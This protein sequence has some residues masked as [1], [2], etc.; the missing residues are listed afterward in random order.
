MVRVQPSRRSWQDC[1][2]CDGMVGMVCPVAIPR[3]FLVRLIKKP[4]SGPGKQGCDCRAPREPVSP[5]CSPQGVFAGFCRRA[6]RRAGGQRGRL[7]ADLARRIEDDQ[8]A[9]SAGCAGG[10]LVSP[11]GP[12]RYTRRAK[13]SLKPNRD[14]PLRWSWPVGLPNGTSPPKEEPASHILRMEAE[15]IP[16]FQIED[17][18][19]PENELKFR[20]DLEYSEVNVE[21]DPLSSGS[22]AAR[23]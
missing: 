14:Y 2:P 13:F 16:A 10:D 17:F 11:S 15:N 12:R 5:A 18:M 21:S 7:A 4:F 9:R 6:A 1:R 23:S 3:R 19:P 22:S 8:S 20:V